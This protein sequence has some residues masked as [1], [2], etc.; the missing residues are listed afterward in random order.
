MMKKILVFSLTLILLFSLSACNTKPYDQESPDMESPGAGNPDS[1]DLSFL[2]ADFCVQD[3]TVLRGKPA[4]YVLAEGDSVT[5]SARDYKKVASPENFAL[6]YSDGLIASAVETDEENGN[7]ALSLLLAEIRTQ[8]P[9]YLLKLAEEDHPC[10]KVA[11]YEFDGFRYFL[12][13]DEND[14]VIQI[15]SADLGKKVEELTVYISQLQGGSFLYKVVEGAQDIPYYLFLERGGNFSLEDMRKILSCYDLPDEKIS[16]DLW[17]DLSSSYISPLH[18]MNE[19]ARSD[20]FAAQ[21]LLLCS[22]F[23][24]K[25]ADLLFQMV[26]QSAF[27]KYDPPTLL[28]QNPDCHSAELVVHVGEIADGEYVYAL[29]KTPIA[30]GTR[31]EYDYTLEEIR[32]ILAASLVPSEKIRVEGPFPTDIAGPSSTAFVTP[33]EGMEGYTKVLQQRMLLGLY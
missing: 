16:L 21:K 27:P 22:P 31:I 19:E 18:Q 32:T 4:L 13:I 17:H 28:T 1:Q 25:T 20:F 7:A 30:S 9:S 10:K 5:L 11:V 15:H 33:E 24:N 29:M 3:T 8:K 12:G 2:I 26:L 6:T 14:S 23:E